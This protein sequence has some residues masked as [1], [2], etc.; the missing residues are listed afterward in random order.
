MG[1]G[2][3]AIARGWAVS[4]PQ[5]GHGGWGRDALTQVSEK[6]SSANKTASQNMGP[7]DGEAEGSTQ[8]PLWGLEWEDRDR[9]T[10]TIGTFISLITM[11]PNQ[12]GL[13]RSRKLCCHPIHPTPHYHP[14]PHEPHTG[15]T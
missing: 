8:R 6:L 3:R 1:P 4:G 15:F 7:E 5:Q 13:L 9:M 11:A 12:T 14:R 2:G 10:G